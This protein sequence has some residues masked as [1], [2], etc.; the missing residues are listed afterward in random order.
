MRNRADGSAGQYRPQRGIYD[1][2]VLQD[3]TSLI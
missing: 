1:V 3:P 2:A